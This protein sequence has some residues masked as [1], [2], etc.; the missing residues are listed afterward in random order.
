MEVDKIYQVLK[1][2]TEISNN[3]PRIEIVEPSTNSRTEVTEIF[4]QNLGYNNVL[5]GKP[6][7]V[8]ETMLAATSSHCAPNSGL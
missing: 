4:K 7:G 5:T 1:Q 6:I 3:K 2:A 8:V